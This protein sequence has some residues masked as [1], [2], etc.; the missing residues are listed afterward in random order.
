M[1]EQTTYFSAY[2]SETRS[3][4]TRRSASV[5]P[6]VLPSQWD[7]DDDEVGDDTDLANVPGNNQTLDS[8]INSAHPDRQGSRDLPR[9]ASALAGLQDGSAWNRPGQSRRPSVEEEAIRSHMAGLRMEDRGPSPAYTVTAR[10]PS[11]SAPTSRRS[12]LRIGTEPKPPREFTLSPIASAAPSRATSDRGDSTSTE[13]RAVPPSRLSRVPAPFSMEISEDDA[14]V[15][16]NTDTTPDATTSDLPTPQRPSILGHPHKASSGEVHFATAPSY[17][18][19]EPEVDTADQAGPSAGRAASLRTFRSGSTTS[20]NTSSNDHGVGDQHPVSSAVHA[21]SAVST[22]HNSPAPS[23]PPSLQ[24]PH[25]SSEAL[26]LTNGSTG[27]ESTESSGPPSSAS[28]QVDDEHLNQ[29]PVPSSI[30][31]SPQRYAE[32]LLGTAPRSGCALDTR[33]VFSQRTSDASRRSSINGPEQIAASSARRPSGQL[34]QDRRV[35][36][37]ASAGPS[38]DISPDGRGRKNASSKFSSGLHAAFDAMKGRVSSKSR[39]R[40]P[41]S[42][43][44]N[45]SYDQNAMPHLN[46]SG[47][48]G[49][50]SSTM[51]RGGSATGGLRSG[52]VVG[53]A[54]P[55]HIIGD[56]DRGSLSRR[57][58]S[59]S[60]VPPLS[61]P[62]QTTT[63]SSNGG[64]DF[65]VPY[66]RGGAARRP[67]YSGSSPAPP[68][69]TASPARIR[70]ESRNGRSPS[71]ARGRN[72]GMKVLTDALGLSVDGKHDEEA[73]E[74]V[75]N[76][77]EFKKGAS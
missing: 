31:D 69:R 11:A 14:D 1:L 76:W 62:P 8:W 4:S 51:S 60:S 20:L 10:Q 25:G 77:K 73:Q 55:A 41:K 16:L 7:L 18:Q 13:R 35:A 53:S 43:S 54:I 12:S 15:G 34:H 57:D 67:S 33:P 22:A 26:H 52:S 59:G 61:N 70:Q 66:G 74:D 49:D 17:H 44:R 68:A 63:S 56:A 39:S 5:G 19:S 40:A 21:I 6:G 9:S 64:S 71:R 2:A 58:R 50:S 46:H 37:N 3:F 30:T 65:M 27:H 24:T 42:S 75:H 36:S 32:A 28:T 72:K 38:R 47:S 45:V 23:K 48:N 29:P